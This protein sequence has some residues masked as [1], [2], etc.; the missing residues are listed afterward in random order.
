[1]NHTE[2]E[3]NK[4][5]VVNGRCSCGI[6]VCEDCGEPASSLNDDL[7]CGF[8]ASKPEENE[9]NEN[10]TTDEKKPEHP[11]R[12]WL[13]DRNEC[14]RL[15]AEQDRLQNAMN[16]VRGEVEPGYY[17]IDGT[18]VVVEKGAKG[19]EIRVAVENAKVI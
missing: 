14:R 3:S 2:N 18:V 11:L 17:N 16:K 19:I 10:D 6:L 9:V 4:H 8:C 7:L 12:K 1:M 13:I 5:E 15:R